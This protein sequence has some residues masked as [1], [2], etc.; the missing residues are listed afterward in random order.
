MKFCN[1]YIS[2]SNRNC[3]KYCNTYYNNIPYC[4]SHYNIIKKREE[5]N[6]KSGEET[7]IKSEEE[8]NIKSKEET[9]IKSK[10]ETNIKSGEKTQKIKNKCIYKMRTGKIC[11]KGAKHLFNNIYYCKRHINILSKKS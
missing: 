8:T 3:I 1:Y 11:E 5:T 9:N 7:N 6:I 10:E 4:R 2:K